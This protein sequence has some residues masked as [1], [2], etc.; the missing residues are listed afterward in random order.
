M[1]SNFEYKEFNVSTIISADSAWLIGVNPTI[2]IKIT[3]TLS[4]KSAI[5]FSP[6]TIRSAIPD[7]NISCNKFSFSRSFA[8]SICFSFSA[9]SVI[10]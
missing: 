4:L 8:N 3:D 7:G 10:L 2:S 5:V 6:S 9:L 1:S